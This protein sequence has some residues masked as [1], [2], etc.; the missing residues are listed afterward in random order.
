MNWSNNFFNNISRNFFIKNTV[1][2]ELIEFFKS[3]G[4]TYT[5]HV[6][7]QCCGEGQLQIALA[8][9]LGCK[10]L[11]LDQCASYIK[12]AKNLAK[13]AEVTSKFMEYDILNGKCVG[14]GHFVINWN[15]S[16][17]YFEDDDLNLKFLK[18]A[19]MHTRKDGTFILEYYNSYFVKNH[20][21]TFRTTEKE[22]DGQTYICERTS[23]I[24][25]DCLISDCVIMDS[26]KEVIFNSSGLTKMYSKDQIVDMLHSVG[27]KNVVCYADLAKNEATL[28][29]PRLIFVSKK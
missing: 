6:I 16:W 11:G 20:F 12:T 26:N 13:E 1:E 9:S 8:Q 7:E 10:S 24:V 14:L 18:N 21:E 27:F 23:K 29:S 22:V 2:P 25:N 3:L 15:T 4:V 19:Y 17:G 28:D 5:S